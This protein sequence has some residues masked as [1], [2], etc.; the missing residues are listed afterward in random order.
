M[1]NTQNNELTKQVNLQ[2]FSSPYSPQFFLNKNDFKGQS[3]KQ[4]M[5]EYLHTDI[6]N[7]NNKD[8]K[9]INNINISEKKI[10]I[11]YIHLK[12]LLERELLELFEQAIEQKK[13]PH[14]KFMP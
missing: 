6:E 4:V 5:S 7:H 9:I 12:K 11:I 14:T 13:L 8:T 3:I 2:S 1:G 10:L